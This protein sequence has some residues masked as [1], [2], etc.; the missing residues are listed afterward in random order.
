MFVKAK[1]EAL[2][3]L[4]DE[5]LNPLKGNHPRMKQEDPSGSSHKR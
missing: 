2:H 4:L 1:G 5:F 3:E